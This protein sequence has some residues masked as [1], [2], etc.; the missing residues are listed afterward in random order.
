M[1]VAM[2][3]QTK[4]LLGGIAVGG[5]IVLAARA[6][7]LKPGTEAA[8]P[9]CAPPVDD[10]EAAE[11]H[12]AAVRP[13]RRFGRQFWLFWFTPLIAI[14]A[15][16]VASSVP[17]F[18]GAFPGTAGATLSAPTGGIIFLIDAKPGSSS[19]IQREELRTK[20]KAETWTT[21]FQ[22]AD[23]LTLEL[24]FPTTLTGARWYIVA[25]GQY[26]P[27][28]DLNTNLFC[29]IGFRVVREPQR[30]RCK[31]T[32]FNGS[33]GV[34][35]RYDDQ[36]GTKG[37]DGKIWAPVNSLTGYYAKAAAI[38]TGIVSA[39]TDTPTQVS[40]PFRTPQVAH[41]GGDDLVRLAPIG[42]F[43]NTECIRRREIRTRNAVSAV[44]YRAN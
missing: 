35:Y 33:S 23:M 38:I 12:G 32:E 21:G 13:G 15:A 30:I 2:K 43:D 31:D 42:V 37:G 5:A 18:F 24:D 9:A 44:V 39:R 20:V 26:L 27:N 29:D 16:C 22:G 7:K 10:P 34:E 3:R 4:T 40:I 17:L 36:I 14:T 19:E 1:V 28:Q 25:S 8:P 6:L 11:A 41:P